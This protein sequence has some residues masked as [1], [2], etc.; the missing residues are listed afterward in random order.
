MIREDLKFLLEAMFSGKFTNEELIET[1]DK[2]DFEIDTP[3]INKHDNTDWVDVTSD[4]YNITKNK[5]TSVRYMILNDVC[6]VELVDIKPSSAKQLTTLSSGGT[7]PK[8]DNPPYN[9]PHTITRNGSQLSS[10]GTPEYIEVY[11]DEY[12]R[13]YLVNDNHTITPD[14]VNCRIIYP[15][16]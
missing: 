1:V 15:L 5:N 16:D 8:P 6:Y 12:G 7:F 13:M 4:I 9:I 11:V 3:K 2:L 14:Y 10:D